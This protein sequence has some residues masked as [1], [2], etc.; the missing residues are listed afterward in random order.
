MIG[1]I[2]GLY[3][4][5]VYGLGIGL[6]VA[7]IDGIGVGSLNHITLVEAISWR[8]SQFSK[9]TIPGLII[10]LV[11]GLNNGLSSGLQVGL[12]AG[13]IYG[14]SGGLVSGLIGGFTDRVKIG[15]ASPNQCNNLS[16]KNCLAALIVT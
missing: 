13:L 3:N 1:L 6:I 16:R 12:K 15:K 11:V 10:G 8:W 9:R 4:G 14:L 7:V 5:L 2:Y